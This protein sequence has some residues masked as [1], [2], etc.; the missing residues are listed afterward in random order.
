MTRSIPRFAAT[1]LALA[2]AA[3]FAGAQVEPNA[4]PD[5]APAPVPV[6][7]PAAP[8][9]APP[10]GV[11]PDPGVFEIHNGNLVRRP[12]PQPA[13]AARPAA[14][15]PAAVAVPGFRPLSFRPG[16]KQR[17]RNSLG[18]SVTGAPAAIREQLK[19]AR[20]VGLVVEKVHAKGPADAAGVKEHDVL[21]K[22]DDQ[23][24][25]NPEQLGAL[26]RGMKA[27]DE[28]AL[29]LIRQGQ[30]E[31][32]KAKVEEV[33]ET[34]AIDA[35]QA[36]DWLISKE[37]GL[38]APVEQLNF[39][40]IDLH[41]APVAGG[42][43]DLVLFHTINGNARTEWSDG[44]HTIALQH[45]DGRATHVT[46]KERK[47]DKPLYDGPREGA[48]AALAPALVDK[49]K[50]A[51]NASAPQAGPIQI[52]AAGDAA[53]LDIVPHAAGMPANRLTAVARGGVGA[54]GKVLRWQ[55]DE[56]V[57]VLRAMGKQ[58]TYLLA[59]SKKDGRVIYDGPVES[60]DQR[61]SLPAEIAEQFQ[62]IVKHPETA[63]EF[64]APAA[65]APAAA[66]AATE[67]PR[68]Q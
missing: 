68:K 59:L 54:R 47:A 8:A 44:E 20:G 41:T 23:W 40:T 63:K 17:K 46:V 48:A 56:L 25:V 21:E 1:L 3:T 51:E 49:V 57:L 26:L 50:Q 61:K 9:V 37:I 66:A 14:G 6:P 55:D 22:L 5:P 32:V 2:S 62:M 28:V 38:A 16:A 10:P 7:D 31:T 18:V 33:E 42:A 53:V 4:K 24:L 12:L 11:A 30:W 35:G 65:A 43:K 45:K 58:P 64:G 19:L 67:P 34:A 29:T 13:P 15:A 39:N 60:E 27:G 52:R 36:G